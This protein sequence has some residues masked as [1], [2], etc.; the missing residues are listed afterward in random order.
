MNVQTSIGIS[1]K[2]YSCAVRCE[3]FVYEMIKR[4]GPLLGH[5]GKQRI[6]VKLIYLHLPL[7]TFILGPHK[8][9]G[10]MKNNTVFLLATKT[11]FIQINPQ[12][13]VQGFFKRL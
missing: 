4:F 6:F 7:F 3:K 11:R 12:L 5:F 1:E 10:K 13:S 9:I 8:S 2:V